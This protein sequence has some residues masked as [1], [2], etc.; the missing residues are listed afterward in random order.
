MEGKLYGNFYG[1]RVN[2]IL[3]VA[4]LVGANIERHLIKD[5]SAL[6]TPEYFAKHP[7]GKMPLL[8]T[9]E[10]CIF[11]SNAICRFLARSKPEAALFGKTTFQGGLVEQWIDFSTTEIE[12][13]L[14]PLLYPIFGY[15]ETTE[16]VR[17][18]AHQDL[19][20]ILAVLN[21]HLNKSKFL[22]GDA[23]TLADIVVALTLT[24]VFRL[25]LSETVRKGLPHLTAWFQTILN[26]EHVKD[27]VG[28]IQLAQNEWRPDAKWCHPAVGGH[29]AQHHEDKKDQPKKEKKEGGH[30]KEE[31]KE[32]P[33]KE[34][35]PKEEK[36]PKKKEDDDEEEQPAPKAKNPLDLLPASTFNLYDFKTLY[37]NAPDKKEAL[38]FFWEH[39]DAAGYSLWTM[40][41]QKAEGEGVKLYLTENLASGIIQRLD[42]FRKYSFGVHG[43]Y[44]DEPNLE[45]KG[46]LVWRGTEHAQEVKDLPNY[47]YHTF[48]KLDHTKEA[49]RNLVE[50]YWTSLTEGAKVDGLTVRTVKYFK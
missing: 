4:K 44:G 27:V 8:E 29:A 37:V 43:V 38:K 42:D 19:S 30:A 26:N 10:G 39:F 31:K 49:D 1:F 16:D 40:Q 3:V 48:V 18:K 22:V 13:H 28:P 25:L 5:V 17:T 34:D 6:K 20:K 50:A 15:R 33:K 11:E 35:K 7:L 41:Y 24:E 46:C 9:K 45:I 32:Q 21:D 47:D 2:K 12:P 36:K 14:V 23:L